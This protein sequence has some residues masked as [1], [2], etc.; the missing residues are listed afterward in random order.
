PSHGRLFNCGAGP[1]ALIIWQEVNMKIKDRYCYLTSVVAFLL[2]IAAGPVVASP[3]NVKRKA[4]APERPKPMRE[5]VLMREQVRPLGESIQS[6]KVRGAK[7]H[8]G[9]KGFRTERG[10]RAEGPALSRNSIVVV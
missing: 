1:I 6:K 9:K 5:V 4:S 2:L 8:P 7:K 3:D 10:L